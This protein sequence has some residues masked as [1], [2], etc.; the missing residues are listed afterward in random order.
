MKMETFDKIIIGAG[1]YGLYSALKVGKTGQKVLILE[2]EKEAFTRASYINQARVHMG[3]HYPRSISTAMKSAGY[4]SRFCEEYS[5][6]INQEF[7]QIYATSNK[8]SWTNG[9]DFNTFCKN[10]AIPC[11]KI[12]PNQYFK[13]G[14][15][16]GAFI[17]KEYCY[18]A[19]ILKRYLLEEI[20]LLANVRIEYSSAPICIKQKG[21][22]WEIDTEKSKVQTPFLL[23]AT[24]AGINEVLKITD[25]GVFSS[26]KIKYEKCEIILCKADENLKKTGITVMDGPFFSIMPFGKTGLHSLTSVT[27][28]PH[29][30]SYEEVASFPCQTEVKARYCH[31][32]P[33]S[34]ENCN[35]C[36]YKPDSSWAYMDSLAKKYLRDEF[37]VTY[38]S[39]L[40]SIKPILM[41][42]E[43][44]DSRPTLIRKHCS[45][46][47]L[48]SVLSGKINTVYDLDEV[49]EDD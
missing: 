33:G 44:D 36:R 26:F 28:T 30:T 24:Y 4:F 29:E 6:C 10:A 40:Y 15:C 14:L 5:F 42:S 22:L 49:L 1:F 13:T 45:N 16:D 47:T 3:Y 41:N 32:V 43:I 27:F 8:L 21:E 38:H 31:C 7:E 37:N 23:N 19:Q 18:D 46:P 12:D 20:S 48:V 11:M 9:E 34:L 35:A 17:T 2:K 39:S 25:G